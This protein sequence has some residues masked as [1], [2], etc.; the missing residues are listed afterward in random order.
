MEIAFTHKIARGNKEAIA[1]LYNQYG[2]KL[3]GYAVSK[4][5]MSEDEAW[6]MVYKTL[7]KIIEVA[8]K[9]T[10]E[11]EQKFVGFIFKV[12]INYL[13]MHYRDTK[14]KKIETVELSDKRMNVAPKSTGSSPLTPQMKVLQEEL[15]KLEDWQRILLLMRA[16]DMSYASIAAY[17][18]KSEDQLKVYYMRL[19]KSIGEKVSER[20]KNI[21]NTE[22]NAG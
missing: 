20:F 4:W 16:Q 3:Y 6:D 9:Y 11:N 15:D 1:F 21:P 19:K 8:D 5:H 12:F 13:R 10:F 14:N 18:N 17:V 2:K 22:Q 7:Y